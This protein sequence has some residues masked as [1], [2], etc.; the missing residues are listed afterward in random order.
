MSCVVM[1]GKR[2]SVVVETVKRRRAYKR[3]TQ[4]RAVSWK[5][6]ESLLMTLFLCMPDTKSCKSV[7]C[8]ST[9]SSCEAGHRWTHPSWIRRPHK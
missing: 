9:S 7:A 6:Q 5:R 2:M 8:L 4:F 1:Y 3:F